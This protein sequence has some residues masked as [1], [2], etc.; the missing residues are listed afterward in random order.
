MNLLMWLQ[1]GPLGWVAES[2]W[3]YPIVLAAHA[4]GMGIVVGTAM[5]VSLR[6]LGFARSVPLQSLEKMSVVAWLGVAINVLS[7]LFLF[8]AD[9]PKFFFHPVFWIKISLIA[10]GAL[11]VWRLLSIVKI[12]KQ[13]SDTEAEEPAG[14]KVIAASALILWTGALVAG[15]LIAYT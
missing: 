12:A 4:V 8:A 14:A 2:A 7:G 1:A 11:S 13:R 6:V 15:R 9:A 3:G 5:M 10:L